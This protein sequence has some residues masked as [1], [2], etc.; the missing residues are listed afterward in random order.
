VSVLFC[1]LVGSTARAEKLDPEDVSRALASYHDR[2]RHELERFG[3]TVEKFIG[4][5]VMAIFGAPVAHEDDPERAVRAAL[6]IREWALDEPDVEVRIGITTGEVL[7]ALEA[8]PERGEGMASGD[9]VNVAARLQSAAPVNGILVDEATFHASDRAITYRE[10]EPVVAKGKAEPVAAWEAEEARSRFGVDVQRAA[11]TPLVGR[12]RELRMLRES[13]DRVREEREPQFVTLVGVPGIGKSRIVFELSEALE[14]DPE[15]I[16]WRQGRCLP[17]GEGVSF[18]ALAEMVKAQAGILE[19]DTPEAVAT[20]LSEA[21]AGLALDD[22]AWVERQL[23]PLVGLEGAQSDHARD[24]SATAWRRFLEGIADKGPAVLVFEDLHWADEGIL[25]FLDDLAEWTS[26]VPLLVLCTARPELLAK[27]PNWGGGRTNSLTLSLPPLS[28]EDTARL[29][30]DLLDRVVLPAEVQQTLLEHAAGNPLYAEEFARMVSERGDAGESIPETVHGII[31]ARL[32]AL[33]PQHKRLLQAAAVIGKV[34]WSGAV[35]A[36]DGEGAEP[37]EEALREL[38][39]RQL[40]RRERRTSVEGQ[41]EYAFLHALVRDVAYGQI[42]RAERS[43][44]HLA[45]AQWTASLGRADDVAEVLAH[46]YLEALDYA[47]AAGRDTGDLGEGARSALREAGERATALGADQSAARYFKAALDLAGDDDS[48]RG[49][50]LFRSATAQHLSDGGGGDEAAEAVALLRERDPETAGRAALIAARAAWAR[51]D[52]EERDRWLEVLDGL[53]ADYPDSMARTEAL[54]W[55]GAFKM[56]SG[57]Y[58]QAIPLSREALP[59]IDADARPD[60]YARALDVI[61][62]SRVQAGDEGGLED[63]W[64]AHDLAREARALYH[65]HHTLNNILVSLLLVGRLDEADAAMQQW[66]RDMQ[67]LGASTYNR[68][69]YAASKANG[70]YFSGKWDVALDAIDAFVARIPP[71]ESNYLESDLGNVSALIRLDR[72]RLADAAADCERAVAIARRAGDLSTVVT[73]TCT[74]ALVWHGQGRSDDAPGRFE[75]ILDTAGAADALPMN[76]LSTAFAW[77]ALDIGRREDAERMFDGAVPRRWTRA[78]KL[79]LDGDA[80]AAAEAL[81]E[82]GHRPAAAYAR[83]RAGGEHARRALEFYE[84]VGAVRRIREAQAALAKSA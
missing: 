14:A 35:A 45:A 77:L 39:R 42:P 4:D 24:E 81:D 22:A 31:A 26:G 62:T 78:A 79:V 53:L 9:V 68:E 49:E 80:V 67:E 20:K 11:R 64:R 46:H 61:G 74:Q 82:I 73:T 76:G 71:G 52:R 50:L 32:D 51:G 23:G 75:E 7:V 28:S 60:L 25:D 37:P 5:A 38:E 59:R 72:D 47:R 16:T 12:Q 84:S 2:V 58:D 30:H 40:V 13:F 33:E 17:Y 54:V 3:G 8:R 21:V 65:F 66:S 27:R 6:A 56:L 34:F 15:F 44:R 48:V 36:L 63:Q 29:A 55:H 18:W 43:D 69:W 57:D 19:S 70:D 83:L 1:D 41:V 10:A